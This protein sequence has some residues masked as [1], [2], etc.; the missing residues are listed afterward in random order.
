MPTTKIGIIGCG[1]ISS[2]YFKACKRFVNMQVVACADLDLARAKAQASEYGIARATTVEQ[3][4]SDPEIEL[5]VNLT[6]PKA[7]A[8]IDCKILEAGKH[9]FS[10]K[11]LALTR[12]EGQ[13]IVALARAKNLRV[14]CAPDTVL[15]AGVQ[16]CRKLIDDGAIGTPVAATAFMMTGGPEHWHPSPEFVYEAGGGPMFDMG[17]YYLHALITLLGPVKRVTGSARI[18]YPERTITSKPKFGQKMLVAIPTHISS[19]LDFASGVV[20]NLVTSFDIKGKHNAPQLEIYGSE[21][22]LQVPDPN[23]TGGPVRLIKAGETAWQEIAHTHLYKEGSRGLGVSDMVQAI[24]SG[25]K[26]RANEEIALHALDIM[27]SIH[28]ASD[29][30][31]H[32][33]LTTTCERPKAMN[34]AMT[35]YVLDD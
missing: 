26:H 9:V 7:H 35:E 5:A 24:H 23:N 28:E 27:Q 14:G 20:C 2:A 4:L 17:P 31:R 25:R 16:T 1:N 11:P 15:G 3:F 34:A 10:E 22:S 29:S 12:A 33:M 19:V 32:V 13:N 30:G 21:G 18:S 8:E 6:I